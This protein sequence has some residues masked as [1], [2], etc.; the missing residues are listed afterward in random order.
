[1]GPGTARNVSGPVPNSNLTELIIG[2]SAPKSA[3]LNV[4]EF[5]II[6]VKVIKPIGLAAV[7]SG[8]IN[9]SPI[10]AATDTEKEDFFDDKFT[11]PSQHLPSSDSQRSRQPS[12][13]ATL[14]FNSSQSASQRTTA[15]PASR[16]STG[17]L[18]QFVARYFLDSRICFLDKSDAAICVLMSNTVPVSSDS[19]ASCQSVKAHATRLAV[20]GTGSRARTQQHRP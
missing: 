5:C 11:I 17:Q 16:A 14:G 12:F 1:M 2:L 8:A 13:S 20:R 10:P 7:G 3:I 4:P 6:R 18:C 15:A 19:K 9:N